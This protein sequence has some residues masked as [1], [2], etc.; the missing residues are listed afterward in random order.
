MWL[1]LQDVQY[2]YMYAIVKT[3]SGAFVEMSPIW[4]KVKMSVILDVE[5][6]HVRIFVLTEG[7]KFAIMHINVL[8]CTFTF[9]WF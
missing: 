8:V 5:W 9:L 2:L 6:K 3:G 4:D 1:N 7:S